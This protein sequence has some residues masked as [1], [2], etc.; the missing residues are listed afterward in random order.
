MT[1]EAH[2]PADQQ[3]P[4][5][6]TRDQQAPV[7]RSPVRR[8]RDQQTPDQRTPDQRTP[9]R[10]TAAPQAQALWRAARQYVGGRDLPE[11]QACTERLLARGCRV[12]LDLFGVDA[13]EAAIGPV[14]ESY[15]ALARSTAPHGADVWLSIDPSHI[16]LPH[17]WSAGLTAL[18]RIAGAL[19]PGRRLQIG[20]ESARSADTTL[21]A[22][23]HLAAAGLPVSATV[24]AN[25]RRSHGDVARLAAARVPVRLVKGAFP[26][27]PA[28]CWRTPAQVDASFDRLA[29]ALH[30]HGARSPW[31]RTTT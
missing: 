15:L 6:R 19:Q 17:S 13:D 11:A 18:E 7:Q 12:S 9:V 29:R 5:R 26:E 21:R 27:D 14:T 16:G 1:R 22:V 31:P 8:T 3:T 20:A 23:L 2:G 30:R 24:Q 28:V 4:V 10:R 25:L